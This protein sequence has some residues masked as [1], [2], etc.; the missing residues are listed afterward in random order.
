MKNN[1]LK[2]Q[3]TSEPSG[4]VVSSMAKPLI[5][6]ISYLPDDQ[7]EAIK[8]AVEFSAHAHE[9]QYRRSGEPYVT[10]PIAVAQ[11][12]A[13]MKL[14]HSAI[15]S[16]LLHDVIEDTP[17]TK[18]DIAN[19]FSLEVANIVDGIS[20]ISAIQFESKAAEQ[21]EN[22]R[23]MVL[24]MAKDIRVILVK[25]A[26]RLHNMRTLGVLKVEKRKR[27]AQET[28]DIYAPIANRLGMNNVRVEYEDLCFQAIYPLR[29]ARIQQ[30][31]RKNRGVTRDIIQRVE[32]DI[33]QI[34]ANRNIE[35]RL[36]CREK[37]L[38]SIYSKMRL[39]R[40]SF[41]SITDV[42]GF[43]IILSSIDAC[44]RCLGVMHQLYPP[45]PGRFKDYIGI[46]KSNG[47]QSVHTTLK[48]PNGVPVEIQIR[49]E[50]M[51]EVAN[52]GVASHWIYKAGKDLALDA[53]RRA[54]NWLASLVEIQ[55]NTGD[56]QEFVENVK[57]DLFPEEVYVFTPKGAI[58]ELPYGATA[59][60]F[61]Y[62]VHTDIGNTCVA[63]RAD[64]VL[65]S[66]SEPLENGKTIQIVTSKSSRP[67][68]KWLKYVI[69]GKARSSIKHYMKNQQTAE[70]QQLGM[71]LLE[72]A[73][74]AQRTSLK[75][76]TNEQIQ[77]VCDDYGCDDLNGIVTQIG[78]G[79][80]IAPIVARQLLCA[81]PH[82][83]AQTAHANF[84]AMPLVI[85]GTEGMVI[86]F[87]KCCYPIPGDQILGYLESGTGLVVHQNSCKLLNHQVRL[88]PEES[89]IISWSDNTSNTFFVGLGIEVPHIS[90][91]LAHVTR[92]LAECGC[93]IE[94][95]EMDI[96]AD[97]IAVITVE[98]PVKSRTHLA[99]IFKR[100]R[101][102]GVVNRMSRL[103][104]DRSKFD[105][106][107]E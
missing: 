77:I 46:P 34:L 80:R 72:K 86:T 79:Q 23:K 30:A 47:Y 106:F 48:G 14:D 41:K 63:A 107:S 53:Q 15:I 56:S 5:D 103:G 66:L 62:A 87:A 65:L 10:H 24:A 50:E 2:S 82:T 44:Y 32:S 16:A 95:I 93:N 58:V 97:Q 83:I 17:Y 55:K 21:A 28:L 78:L 102:S 7:I 33:H 92:V 39:H 45:I 22:F 29:S 49:T 9:G 99:R 13:E 37:H 60:D 38:F 104:A 61:A 51:D 4:D 11:I 76:L 81:T 20:K 70:S 67:N 31:V 54:D 52:N 1:A 91:N 101:A 19:R 40:R 71:R 42:F 64:D 35:Y 105:E 3:L 43:R 27:I 8:L 57:T 6:K 84:E 69:T 26:D 18:A 68:P 89:L 59:V 25:L 98:V 90:G 36:V 73:L 88:N 74:T 12:I 100:M 85:D 94:R 96:R 75:Q